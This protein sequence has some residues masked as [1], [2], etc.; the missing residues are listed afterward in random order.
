MLK[1]KVTI[2]GLCVSCNL[3]KVVGKVQKFYELRAK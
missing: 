1:I 2:V 3:L